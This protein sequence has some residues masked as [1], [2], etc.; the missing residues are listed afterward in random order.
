MGVFRFFLLI[1]AMLL[2][3]EAFW[4]RGIERIDM[5]YVEMPKTNDSFRMSIRLERVW[6]C[7]PQSKTIATYSSAVRGSS[8]R[9]W[10][11]LQDQSKGKRLGLKYSTVKWENTCPGFATTSWLHIVGWIIPL[12]EIEVLLGMDYELGEPIESPTH[13]GLYIWASLC[14]VW[15]PDWC[16]LCPPTSRTGNKWRLPLSAPSVMQLSSHHSST[17]CLKTL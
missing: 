17:V 6:V 10:E 1:W 3:L 9:L 16:W 12:E 13:S 7:V 11:C 14:M 2:C 4:G 15:N 8:G 5:V